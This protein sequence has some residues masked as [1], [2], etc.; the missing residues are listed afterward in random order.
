MTPRQGGE[1][2]EEEARSEGISSHVDSLLGMDFA[3]ILSSALKVNQGV[4]E[5]VADCG[6]VQLRG[7]ICRKRLSSVWQYGYCLV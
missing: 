7:D 1:G 6:L 2:E 4:N 3:I 5:S